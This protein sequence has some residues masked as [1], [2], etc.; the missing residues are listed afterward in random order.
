MD[1]SSANNT[2]ELESSLPRR[3]ILALPTLHG[4]IY[5]CGGWVISRDELRSNL[6]CLLFEF[7]RDVCVE[8]YSAL[9][10][11]GLEMTAAS[12]QALTELCRCTPY[13]FDISSHTVKAVDHSTLVAAT[14][15]ISTLEIVHAQLMVQFVAESGNTIDSTSAA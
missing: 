9:V 7:P 4:M 1:R 3:Q 5:D 8:I 14:D 12:H 13:L 6:S 2:I 10:S 15:Y 11:V